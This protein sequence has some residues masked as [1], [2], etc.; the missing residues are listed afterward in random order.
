[1]TKVNP[2]L[3]T[4]KRLFNWWD[5][6]SIRL[7]TYLGSTHVFAATGI[8]RFFINCFPNS[9]DTAVGDDDHGILWWLCRKTAGKMGRTETFDIIGISLFSS[10]A[11]FLFHF[12]SMMLTTLHTSHYGS[13][14]G[15]ECQMCRARLRLGQSFQ[16]VF[17]AKSLG[18]PVFFW[19]AEVVSTSGVFLWYFFMFIYWR[20]G[21]V[22]VLGISGNIWKHLESWWHLVQ[23]PV[24]RRSEVR[25]MGSQGARVSTWKQ[26]PSGKLT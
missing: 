10:S 25:C 1:M 9:A 19:K 5:H 6:W 13:M 7:E 16:G 17:S 4:P 14:A 22:K 23:V 11:F 15:F 20:N 12:F 2:G 18:K 8:L 21:L 26:I 24:R 3:I